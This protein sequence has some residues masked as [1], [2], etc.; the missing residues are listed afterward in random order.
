[1]RVTLPADIMNRVRLEKKAPPPWRGWTEIIPITLGILWLIFSCYPIIYMVFTSLRPQTRFFTDSP[2]LPSPNSTPEN[3]QTVLSNNFVTYFTNSVFVTAIS[4][5]LIVAMA[6]FASYAICRIR[7]RFTQIVFALFL[8]GLAIP[9]QAT[10]IPIYVM[11]AAVKLYDTLYAL[12]LPYVAFGLPLSILV[13]VTYIRDIPKELHESM[14]LDGAGHFQILRSLVFPLSRP[15]LIICI[16]YE[17]IQVWNGFLFPL[18][19]TQSTEVRVLPLAL[20]TFQGEYTIN[21]PAVMAAVILSAAPIILLYIFGRRQLL[22]GLT[23]GF[24]K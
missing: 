9:L 14:I 16:I 18:V 11:L 15:A 20:W 22:S 23:A 3:Y 10:I 12:I 5:L 21:V 2:W 24:G 1:M 17:S 4:V 7:N 19:M 13:L 6:L 8:Q